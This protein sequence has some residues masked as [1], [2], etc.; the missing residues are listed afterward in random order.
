MNARSEKKIELK[1]NSDAA[2]QPASQEPQSKSAM[3][4]IAVVCG[5]LGILTWAPLF[6]PLGLVCSVAALF[7][8]RVL[9]GLFGMVLALIGFITSPTLLGVVGLSAL[10]A[11]FGQ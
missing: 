8:G 5:V 1:L 2:D 4:W 11:Y 7:M 10:V 6:V 9:L 3:G